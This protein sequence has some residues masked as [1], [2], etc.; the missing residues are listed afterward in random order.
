MH[1]SLSTTRIAPEI[2]SEQ[3][4]SFVQGMIAMMQVAYRETQEID[5]DFNQK[6]LAGR[7]GKEASF[8]SRCLSGQQN[9]TTRTIHDLARGMDCRLD[10]VFTP[11]RT[12]KPVNRP[13]ASGSWQDSGS[14]SSSFYMIERDAA[15]PETPQ[16]YNRVVGQ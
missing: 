5:P 4:F 14:T 1:Y 13:L 16:K 9:M 11:L 7:I 8:V 3:W 6:I 15:A 10:V 2:L 12:L